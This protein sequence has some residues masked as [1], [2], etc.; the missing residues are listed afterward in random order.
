MGQ[1]TEKTWQFPSPRADLQKILVR[2]MELSP[3]IAQVLINRGISSAEEARS[4]LQGEQGSLTD[5]LDLPGMDNCCQRLALAVKNKE[6]VLVYGDYDADGVTATAL[7]YE[8]LCMLGVDT[9]YYIPG[10]LEEGYGINIPALEKARDDGYA[11][12]VTVD[13]GISSSQEVAFARTIGLDLIITDHHE[14]PEVLP[15][16]CAVVNPKLVKGQGGSQL[17]GVGVAFM[18]VRALGRYMGAVHNDQFL[19]QHF[20]DLVTIGTIADLVPLQGDNRTLVARGL[21]CLSETKRTGLQALLEVAGL[22]GQPLSS[23]QVGYIIGPRINAT[24]RLSNADRGVELLLTTSSQRAWE[25]ANSLHRENEQRQMIESQILASVEEMINDQ[26]DLDR[27]WVIVLASPFWHQG[28][29]GIVA[30]RVVEKYHRPAILIATE[31]DTG[32]GSARSIP[33]FDLYRALEESQDL[34]TRFGGH[35]IAA[36]LT[37]EAVNIQLLRDRLNF[38]AHDWLTAEHLNPTL[39]VDAEMFFTLLDWSTVSQLEKLEPFGSGNA[40]PLFT[41]RKARVTRWKTVGQN[42]EHLKL[43]LRGEEQEFDAIGFRMAAADAT[44]GEEVDLAFHVE[45]NK[46][47]GRESIQLKLRD[48]RKHRF[49]PNRQVSDTFF[50]SMSPVQREVIVSLEKGMHTSTGL[51]GWNEE[52]GIIL[53]LAVGMARTE[54]AITV[55]ISPLFPDAGF[56]DFLCGLTDCVGLKAAWGS[57]FLDN[58]RI[59]G[60]SLALEEGRVD[61]LLAT[62]E[63][64]QAL[65]ATGGNWVKQV[66]LLI[67]TRVSQLAAEC[68]DTLRELW[69]SLSCPQVLAAGFGPGNRIGIN[70]LQPVNHI[71]EELPEI[72]WIDHRGEDPYMSLTSLQEASSPSLIMVRGPREAHLLVDQIRSRF[73]ALARRVAVYHQDLALEQ[74]LAVEQMVES[75]VLAAVIATWSVEAML[76]IRFQQVFIHHL[77]FNPAAL[78]P[79]IRGANRVLCFWTGEDM[80]KEHQK[81]MDCYPERSVVGAVFQ[82]LIACGIRND[83]VPVAL[84]EKSF[85]GQKERHALVTSLAIMEELGLIVLLRQDD[86]TMVKLLPAGGKKDLHVSWRYREGERLRRAWVVL[87][88]WASGRT[89][90]PL[91]DIL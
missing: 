56:G 2:E 39:T 10:R 25:L 30:S 47:N 49:S 44:L 33:G 85:V 35:R 26:I 24:G 79:W 78:I 19:E 60:L 59:D 3:L 73:P 27:E 43:S 48:I 87:H 91:L 83:P 64:M 5:P 42:N 66:G 16:A 77:P 52:L 82:R 74:R 12:V 86:E 88:R 75:N 20:L 40:A 7:L 58:G 1:M 32:K 61:L 57:S 71:E 46:W 36:G 18:V 34:L 65:I 11:L 70:W 38:L 23:Y 89:I 4:F 84:I 6:R 50:N 31:G 8:Y 17:A 21:K 69:Q 81:L 9:G 72:Y 90:L 28:V 55:V 13:C 45:R 76:R 63:L 80:E 68:P 41:Y 22:Q 54:K 51:S 53:P 62:P 37:V 67:F 15:P 14:P 29:I